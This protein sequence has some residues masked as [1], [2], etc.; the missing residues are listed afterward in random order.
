MD[1]GIGITTLSP[2]AGSNRLSDGALMSIQYSACSAIDHKGH[3]P[4]LAFAS[5]T[6]VNTADAAVIGG[7]QERAG[8]RRPK[9]TR[10]VQEKA[11]PGGSTRMPD[12]FAPAA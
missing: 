5:S 12:S 2:V 10:I 11:A 1:S 3:S 7:V 9:A 8:R 4:R 6:Q